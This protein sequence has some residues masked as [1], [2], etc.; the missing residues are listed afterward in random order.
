MKLKLRIL[1]SGIILISVLSCKSQD[2]ELTPEFLFGKWSQYDGTTTENGIT[3]NDFLPSSAIK[4]D[5]SENGTINVR[6]EIE[7]KM[8]WKLNEQNDLLIGIDKIFA[9]YKPKIENDSI[10]ILSREYKGK[11]F[12]YYFKKGWSE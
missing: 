6:F 2:P 5:F 8:E 9:E 4:Y 7:D 11:N 1:I 12:S 10:L 3:K